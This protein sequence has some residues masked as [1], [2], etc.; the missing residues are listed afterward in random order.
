MVKVSGDELFPGWIA[1]V[2]EPDTHAGVAN[3]VDETT[4]NYFPAFWQGGSYPTNKDSC[5]GP[6]SECSLTSDGG[7]LCT[8]SVTESVAFDSLPVS[9]DDALSTLFIGAVDPSLSGNIYETETDIATLITAHKNVDAQGGAVI[10]KDTIFAVYEERT[11][12]TFF[13]KNIISTVDVVGTQLSFRNAP[14]FMRYDY[15]FISQQLLSWPVIFSL[16][17]FLSAKLGD[18]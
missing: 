17:S 1:I 13:L 18:I 12:R 5:G 10:D 8:T 7:C 16:C 15:L 4:M 11:G 14:H 6:G 3:H 9:V 2:H